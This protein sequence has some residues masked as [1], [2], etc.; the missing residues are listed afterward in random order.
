MCQAASKIPFPASTFF[1]IS[2]TH[3]ESLSKYLCHLNPNETKCCSCD[4]EL[5]WED[6]CIDARWTQ[7]THAHL[8]TYVD[9]FV[10]TQK[11][12]YEEYEC[13]SFVYPLDKG[14][15]ST[16]V[17]KITGYHKNNELKQCMKDEDKTKMQIAVYNT[18]SMEVYIN[19]QCAEQ[20]NDTN[21]IKVNIT[22]A[23]QHVTNVSS[24]MVFNMELQKQIIDCVF[25]PVFELFKEE[26]V[27]LCPRES[28]RCERSNKHFDLCKAY[29]APTRGYRNIHCHKCHT[30]E[31]TSLHVD[32]CDHTCLLGGCTK[33]EDERYTRNVWFHLVANDIDEY[34]ITDFFHHF[35]LNDFYANSSMHFQGIIRSN[36]G[37]PLCIDKTSNPCGYLCSCN[38]SCVVFGTCCVNKLW[39]FQFKSMKDYKQLL[40]NTTNQ[41][42]RYKCEKVVRWNKQIR[43]E[44]FL[45]I[46][47]CLPG[48][49][50]SFIG[51]CSNTNHDSLEATIPVIGED[52]NLYRNVFCALCNNIESFEPINVV[53]NTCVPN[54]DLMVTFRDCVLSLDRMNV[55]LYG[56]QSCE[57]T[58]LWGDEICD[59][60]NEYYHL[61]NAYI[62]PFGTFKNYHCY[63]CNQNGNKSNVRNFEPNSLECPG[64]GHH[65]TWLLL[66]SLLSFYHTYKIHKINSSCQAFSLNTSMIRKVLYPRKTQLHPA[67]N[68][69]F[70][71]DPSTLK[72][73]HFQYQEVEIDCSISV[74]KHGKERWFARMSAIDVHISYIGSSV[75]ILSYLILSITFYGFKRLH[76]VP[77]MCTSAL[78]LSLLCGDSLFLIAG[79]LEHT[80][81]NKLSELCSIVAISMHL[82]LIMAYAWGIVISYDVMVRFATINV[83]SNDRNT[84]KF[85]RYCKITSIPSIILVAV[86]FI[87]DRSKLVVIGYGVDGI[88]AP[89]AFYG[90]LYFYIIPSMLSFLLSLAFLGRTLFKIQQ[91]ISKTRHSL[92]H[93][94]RNEVN[95]ATLALKLVLIL[96]ISEVIGFIQIVKS[97]LSENEK[98]FNAILGLL[99]TLVR[100]TRG[101]VMLIV[102][103]SGK[104]IRELYRA[105]VRSTLGKYVRYHRNRSTTTT[106]TTTNPVEDNQGSTRV[107]ISNRTG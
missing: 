30:N 46:S 49:N 72:L 102:Y 92:E 55:E 36:K 2:N 62:L 64:V 52:G 54:K 19:Q 57:N 100:S 26:D 14:H 69:F 32:Q 51:K 27:Y 107:N 29:T 96:G 45:M 50:S 38:D 39:N 56:L 71:S 87:L 75:S 10:Y 20:Y 84:G 24:G 25:E 34:I 93:S 89:H 7:S 105:L 101:I 82:G 91:Q 4:P 9:E 3:N 67:R 85:K 6:C 88:C 23:C 97:N 94:G 31:S 41:N 79:I 103:L 42:N 47:D 18:E 11:S 66:S 63:L 68:P 80:E 58:L 95:V 5:C 13:Q 59:E 74:L 60:V 61:C 65:L 106:R 15:L 1:N 81:L 104:E 53:V 8:S 40:I 16:S 99:Y 28:S 76:N 17:L 83:S 12:G 48:Q 98:K 86:S 73:G 77:G 35:P 70:T 37:I 43:T 78:T 22:V 44:S 90:R 21:N 33:R